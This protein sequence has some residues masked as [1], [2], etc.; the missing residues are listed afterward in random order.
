ML[1]P[2][3]SHALWHLQV[4]ELGNV[5]EID[6]KSQLAPARKHHHRH[7]VTGLRH[8]VVAKDLCPCDR[9]ALAMSSGR[10]AISTTCHDAPRMVPHPASASH[11][12]HPGIQRMQPLQPLTREADRL[13]F[14]TVISS[15]GLPAGLLRMRRCRDTT[16]STTARRS[17][18]TRKAHPEFL[19]IVSRENPN[20]HAFYKSI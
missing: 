20:R 16:A 17:R 11:Q 12:S 10:S 4:R 2:S 8:R 19:P 3:A 13:R 18:G 1:F 5:F 14:T 9:S 15:V 6:R 7:A